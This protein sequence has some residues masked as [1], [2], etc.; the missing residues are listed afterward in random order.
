MIYD[1]IIIGAGAAGLFA[2]AS[3]S[4]PVN[5]LSK[6][7]NLI[8]GLIL[9]KSPSPGKKLLMAGSGQCNLTHSGDIKDFIS[10]YGDAGPKIRS[11]LYRFNNLAVRDFFERLGVPLVEREDGKVFPASLRARD[12]L[13][14]LLRAAG[15][16]GFEL[17]CLSP[18][19]DISVDGPD[20][21]ADPGERIFTVVSGGG[22]FRSRRLV[23][24]T[25]GC[26]YP[27]TGSD[28]SMFPILET[29]GHSI[30][31]PRPALV[32]LY[33]GNYP[34]ASLAGIAVKHVHISIGDR[35]G[36]GRR[37]SFG[38]LLFTHES[39]SGPAVLDLSR[40][41]RAGA[42]LSIDYLPGVRLDD[43]VRELREAANGTK[44]QIATV[45]AELPS[46]RAAGCTA[47]AVS[48]DGA[49]ESALPKRFLEALASRAG[50]NLE[51]KASSLPG[52]TLKAI[53]EL[54]KK[55]SFTISG[56]G[57]FK[58]AMATAGGIP[59]D[60]VSNRSLESKR[61]RHLYIIGEA[62]DVDG[63]T[64]GYNLQF[65]FSSGYLASESF[66]SRQGG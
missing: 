57:G 1:V 18:V 8:L 46:V 40:Y 43:L 41:A 28:G 34:Y 48:P 39:F 30:V 17:R 55:D 50:A 16:N 9:E 31:Q 14:A 7:E 65:A 20:D 6:N 12:V 37:E 53:A 15:E 52:S 56:D 10:C 45:L 22:T 66:C 42:E 19:T 62:L 4:V 13:E 54:L 25:G 49:G 27:S 58:T 29:L 24:A 23:V 59:L 5:G 2:A 32:P 63:N 3:A 35:E 11:I 21:E 26:S 64:G 61:V 44:K 47:G 33:V 60:E 38:P 51:I 36:F